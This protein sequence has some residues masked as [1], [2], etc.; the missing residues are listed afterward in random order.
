LTKRR[1]LYGAIPLIPRRKWGFVIRNVICYF[2]DHN[3]LPQDSEGKGRCLRCLRPLASEYYQK[4]YPPP[5][6]PMIQCPVCDMELPEDDIPEQLEHLKKRHPEILAE[7]LEKAGFR[8]VDG[9]WIDML[10]TDD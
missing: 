1:L 5:P 4:R 9:A 2:A 3:P 8:Q 10:A 6:P 7:R